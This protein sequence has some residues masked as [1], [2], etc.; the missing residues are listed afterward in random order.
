MKRYLKNRDNQITLMLFIVTMITAI[1]PL[2]SRYC[3]NGHDIEYHLLRIESLKEG[4]LI[5]HPFMKVNTLF[6]GGAGYASSMFYSDLF[7]HIPAL[8]RVFHVSIGKSFHIYTVM[9]FVL[10]YLSAFYCVWK[11]TRSK[12]AGSVAAILLT[13]CPYHMDDMV[14][15]TACGENAAFIFVPIAVYGVYNV[16][17]EDM[18][19]PLMFGLG[20]AGL[21]L[22]HTSTLIVTAGFAFAVF[23]ICIRHFISKP[24]IFV[25]LCIVSLLALL[26]TAYQ[27]VPMLEQFASA[28]FYV[29]DNWTDLLDSA[30]NFA[31]IASS[32]FPCIG[33][34]LFG[35]AIP[36]IFLSKRDCPI[37]GFADIMLAFAAV[38]AI[39]ST[40]IM[41]WE[42]VARYFGFLQFPWRL[43][44]VA[45]VLLA[46]ADAIIL[47]KFV[48]KADDM[49][50][51]HVSDMA[52]VTVTFVMAFLAIG[53]Q[54]ENSM[55]Y[56]DYSDDYYSYKPYTANVIAGEWLPA[57]VEEPGR[58]V[59]QSEHM[60]FDDGSEAGFERNKGKIISR[61]EDSHIYV[62]V[63]FIYYK[64]YSAYLADDQGNNTKLE[65]TDEG[66]NGMCRVLLDGAKGT[67]TVYYAGTIL[68]YV[69]LA[70]SVI[71]ILLI[72][73]LLY[74]KNKYKKKL[75]SRAA[76]AGANLG[77]IACI[78]LAVTATFLSGC[79]VSVNE[80]PAAD[81]TYTNPD[82][83]I[84]YLKVKNNGPDEESVHALVKVN[85]SQKGYDSNASSYALLI[86][87]TSGEQVISVITL[88]DAKKYT[89]EDIPVK[90]SLYNELL[91]EEVDSV[92]E[93]FRTDSIEC[94]VM[95]ETNAL[96]CMEVFPEKSSGFGIDVLAVKLGEDIMSIPTDRLENE[97]DKYNFSAVLAKA[98]Y[99]MDNWERAEEASALAEQYFKEAE[100]VAD[101]GSE[102]IAS[103]LWAAAELYRL[104]GQKT[105]RSVVDAIAMDTVPE[106]F[107]YEDP[108]FFGLFAYLMSPHDTN[109]NVCNN[110]M[111]V[112]F[113]KANELIRE[114]VENEFYDVRIDDKTPAEDEARGTMMLEEAGLVTMT[115]YVSVSVEYKTFVQDRL[116]FIYGANLSGTDLTGE[117]HILHDMPKLF[118]LT[119]LATIQP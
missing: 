59:G 48:E 108:G 106:G 58:L 29:S 70:T 44:L 16:L 75:R 57:T 30:V 62:D 28:K 74:L 109:R 117:D 114:P 92:L 79:S 102:P 118:V 63:P 103:R 80:M 78:V 7:M 17:Y 3:I 100:L 25:K 35:F 45:S 86:D 71:F 91:Q 2:I 36:R 8:L 98:A 83:M 81:A 34:V 113:F 116:S 69:S 76:A 26:V 5:G 115:D 50:K 54:N 56:Y 105:Y 104:T 52:V 14:V 111:E 4:I 60:V 51:G 89:D 19:R 65:V 40:N 97:S 107:T 37:L 22:T 31:D 39:G 68:Q 90:D 82:D 64:G 9:I 55:G 95:N 23:L 13:L 15:R 99:V 43:F 88:D 20:F 38:F 72:F 77:R 85:Y 49:Q 66:E 93:K 6:Y 1:S 67:L 53:H 27:W 10:T 61:I 46:M 119:G 84:D 42:K 110:M 33:F 94:R 112:V 47:Q 96:L 18:D 21:I 101:D 41:P 73:D 12:F 24:R 87:E 11:M 32:V